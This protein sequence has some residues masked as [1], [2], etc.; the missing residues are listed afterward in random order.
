[1]NAGMRSI[2]DFVGPLKTLF[3][4]ACVDSKT[5]VRTSKVKIF[6]SRIHVYAFTL[7]FLKFACPQ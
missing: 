1:M 2:K 6:Q 3:G 5:E 4:A 7:V